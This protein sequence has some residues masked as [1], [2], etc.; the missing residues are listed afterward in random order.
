M[1]TNL[2]GPNDNY[3]LES[4]YVL[5]AFI[6]KFHEAKVSGAVDVEMW[7]ISKPRREFLYVDDMADACL[8]LMNQYNEAGFLNAGYG[9]DISIADLACTVAEVVGIKGILRFN[10]DKPVGTTRKL[11]DSSRLMACIGISTKNR[12]QIGHSLGL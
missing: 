3:D 9:S 7:G 1:P 12:S 5:P 11:M 4:S 8:L 6:R 10:T 2:Y